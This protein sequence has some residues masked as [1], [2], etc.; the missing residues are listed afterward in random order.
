[1]VSNQQVKLHLL[2]LPHLLLELELPTDSHQVIM[3][4][5]L[6]K[7]LMLQDLAKELML[8][9]LA[10]ELMLQDLAKGLTLQDLVKLQ[11]QQEWLTV[12]QLLVDLVFKSLQHQDQMIN[13]IGTKELIQQ[14]NGKNLVQKTQRLLKR[15]TKPIRTKLK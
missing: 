4:Q 6:A 2:R 1:V 8:Q 10:K 14:W 12:Q 7:E 5:D 11:Q 9:D 13:G 3:L 15:A